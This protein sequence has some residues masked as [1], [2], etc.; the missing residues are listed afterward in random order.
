MKR[1]VRLQEHDMV[2]W[3]AAVAGQWLRGTCWSRPDGKWNWGEQTTAIS[4]DHTCHD[5]FI[6]IFLPPT[7]PPPPIAWQPLRVCLLIYNFCTLSLSLYK[8][9]HFRTGKKKRK[10]EE[11]REIFS[12]CIFFSSSAFIRS[13]SHSYKSAGDEGSL[14]NSSYQSGDSAE[15]GLEPT[16]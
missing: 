10:K 9:Q 12:Y 5:F 13:K 14:P 7:P 1:D 2:P 15:A 8:W 16:V 3:E 11:E 4:D 6:F